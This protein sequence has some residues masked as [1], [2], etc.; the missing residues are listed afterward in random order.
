MVMVFWS[1]GF[2]DCE[3]NVMISASLSGTSSFDRQAVALHF[4]PCQL[5]HNQRVMKGGNV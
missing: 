3:I 5:I 4:Q 1:L 2:R